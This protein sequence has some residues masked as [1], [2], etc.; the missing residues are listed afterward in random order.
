MNYPTHDTD[1]ATSAKG[2]SWRRLGGL[3]LIVGPRKDG[4]WWARRGESFLKGSF[5]SKSSAMTA[6][7]LNVDGEEASSERDWE[8]E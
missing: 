4:R 2:N 3:V 6:A 1:W 8:D 5:T 7:E